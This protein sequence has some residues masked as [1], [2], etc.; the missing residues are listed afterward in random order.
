MNK[1]AD[2]IRETR[3]AVYHESAGDYVFCEENK[4]LYVALLKKEDGKYFIP[5]GHL[6]VGE[7]AA[8]AALREIREELCL[9]DTP[10]K[11]LPRPERK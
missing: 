4:T 9:K 5:K 8:Q 10:V 1:K 6:K 2:K 11:S 7:T 3:D